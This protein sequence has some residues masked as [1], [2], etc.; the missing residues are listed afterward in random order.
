MPNYQVTMDENTYR[1]FAA[2]GKKMNCPDATVLLG[3]AVEALAQKVNMDEAI[4]ANKKFIDEVN[5]HLLHPAD[6]EGS[7]AVF[8]PPA[9][10]TEEEVYSLCAANVDWGGAPAV[11]TCWKPTHAH[12][13]A[14]R[15]TGRLWL[16]QMAHQPNP[17]CLS[18]KNPLEFQGIELK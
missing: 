8:G 2:I 18:A 11:L 14:I 4:K 5:N 7:N 17:V 16:A 9:G 10:K 15:K 3:M 1:L 6:F 13:K 12:L